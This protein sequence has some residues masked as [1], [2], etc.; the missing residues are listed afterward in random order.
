MA[1]STPGIGSGL[2]VNSI[3]SQ[4]MAVERQPLT[5][6]DKKEA[7]YQAKLSAYGNL[8]S[9][10]SSFQGTVSALNSPSKYTALTATAG[11]STILSAKAYSTA[12][13]SSHTVEVTQLAQA[14]TLKTTFQ[15]TNVTDLVGVGT[16]TF[17]AGTYDSGGNTFT[18]NP[19]SGAQTVTIDSAHNS[20]AGVRDAINAAN[21]NVSASIVNDGTSN[22]L[23]LTAKNSGAANSMKITVSDPTTSGLAAK[24]AYDPTVVP[25]VN[26]VIQT[27]EAKDAKLLVDGVSITS[28]TN[29]VTSAIQGVTLTLTKTNLGS[30]TTLTVARDPSGISSLVSD[31]VKGYNEL[32]KTIKDLTSYDAKTKKGG[33]L[34]G[35]SAVRSIQSQM[36]AV[37]NT[38]VKDL[39]G[40]Q[41]SLSSIGISFQK[42]GT[43]T[44]D[45]SKLSSAISSDPVNVAGLFTA[46]G[47]PSDSLIQYTS[48]TSKTLPGSYP[49]VISQIATQGKVVAA[50]AAGL[51]ITTGSNDTLGVTL[52]GVSAS[53]T[54]S[55]GLYTAS[56]LLA[57]V[58][59]KINGASAFT[60]AGIGVTVSDDGTGKFTITSNSYGSASTVGV[61]G[62][63]ASNLLGGS[64]TDTIGVDAAG[65][66]NGQP[67]SG[68]GQFLTSGNGLKILVNGGATGNRGTL[69]FA[70]GYA[71]QLDSLITSM[72]GTNGTIDSRTQGVNNSIKDIG[73]RRI[74]LNNRM[75]NIEAMYR[76]QFTSLDTL[77]SNMTKTSNFLTQQLASLQKTN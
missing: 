6:L 37:L 73:N 57:E 4:L 25:P 31:F 72:L 69:N 22:R 50:G 26:G 33:V 40:S 21:I 42:D 46:M 28:A 32:A 75:T 14:N 27:A 15:A 66:I 30:P 53:V 67:A 56:T 71:V 52:N 77:I 62:N 58:Q 5:V 51:T 45:S 55:A 49:I 24:M 1:I 36:R 68:S 74:S 10:V 70:Q 20:L 2:D 18:P 59:S 11:D 17:Y 8:K 65:T 3:V 61:S 41:T 44:L 47:K 39:N 63:A 16:L 35:D 34:L 9:A 19:N 64:S 48:S 12:S 23:M 29:S 38:A 60:S 76:K 7:S 54:L 43:L 13:P